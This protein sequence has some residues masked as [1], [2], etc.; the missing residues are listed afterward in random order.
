MSGIDSNAQELVR[1]YGPKYYWASFT[2]FEVPASYCI[3]L[4]ELK[5]RW[6]SMTEEF[7]SKNIFY[8]SKA[9][10]IAGLINVFDDGQ[11]FQCKPPVDFREFLMIPVHHPDYA[12][13]YLNSLQCFAEQYKIKDFVLPL[14]AVE[15]YEKAHPEMLRKTVCGADTPS[16]GEAMQ[17]LI[18]ALE[19]VPGDSLVQNRK[20]ILAAILSQAGVKAET[21]YTLLTG[22]NDIALNG[23]QTSVRRWREAGKEILGF[24]E[25]K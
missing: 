23:M 14:V 2:D 5:I 9:L 10:P 8:N 16:N 12:K 7:I 22:K 21:A 1:L 19:C 11:I 20:Q 24:P 25:K 4:E 13:R 6:P 15:K 3:T 18:V 17:N